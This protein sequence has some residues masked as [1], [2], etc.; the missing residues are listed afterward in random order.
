MQRV[1]A[2]RVRLDRGDLVGADPPQFRNA[3]CDP[4]ALELVE[5]RQLLGAGGDDQLARP[6]RRDAPPLAVRVELG[7]AG[8]AQPRLQ[9][10]RRVVDAGVDDAAGMAGLVARDPGRRLEHRD[11]DAVV[12][13]RQLARHGEAHDPGADDHDVGLPRWL[14]GRHGCHTSAV[15]LPLKPPIQPQLAL[16]RK[17]LPGDDGWAYEPK[18]DGFRAIAFVDGD[19]LFLQSRTGRPLARYFPELIFP[20]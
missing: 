17:Q 15:S 8:D 9:R 7:G 14:A 13:Q 19:E 2:D 1:D 6:L 18:Y 4:P 5:A 20:A 11:A 3:V 10:A 12:A 16:S